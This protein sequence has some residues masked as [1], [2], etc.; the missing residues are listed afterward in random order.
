ML[1]YAYAE[2]RLTGLR[3]FYW[4]RFVSVGIPY[5]CWNLIYFFCGLP[6]YALRQLGAPRWRTSAACSTPGTTS[7]TSCS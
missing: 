5:L 3:R 4:R 6:G 7:C 1:T 2:M